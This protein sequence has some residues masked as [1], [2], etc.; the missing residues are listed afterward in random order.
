MIIEH[1]KWRMV[2]GCDRVAVSDRG[3]IFSFVEMNFISGTPNAKGYLR[4]HL[5][6]GHRLIHRVVAD[7]F[8]PRPK[9]ANAQINHKNGK[10]DDNRLINLEWCTPSENLMHAYRELGRKSA[11]QG[12]HLSDETKSKISSANKGRVF[13]SEWHRKNSESRKGK[14]TLG[15]NPRAKKTICLE[16]GDVFSCALEAAIKMGVGRDSIYQSIRKGNRANGKW[17]FSYI[18]DDDNDNDK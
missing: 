6:R 11:T 10:K 9:N 7:A 2:D 16:T 8:L 1:E 18:K 17:H 13:S 4:V 12:K 15:N 14:M 5:P 3:R